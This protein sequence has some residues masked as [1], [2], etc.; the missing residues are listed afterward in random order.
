MGL[1]RTGVLAA[2]VYAFFVVAYPDGQGRLYHEVVPFLIAGG[3]VGL[4]FLKKILDL[5]EGMLKFGLELAFLAAIAL[6]V[7]YTMPQKSGKPPLQQWAEGAR[8]R[9]SE[10][11]RGLKRLSVDPDGVVGKAV[12]WP[13]A[14]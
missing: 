13:F 3:V 9:R 10:V 7:G 6:T 8:P 4:G 5:G 11:R 1:I 12:Q 14:W 2:A